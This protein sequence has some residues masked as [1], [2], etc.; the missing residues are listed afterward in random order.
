MIKYLAVFLLLA[1]APVSFEHKGEEEK[2]L[3]PEEKVENVQLYLFSAPWCGPCK[4]MHPEIGRQ[5]K[6]AG[7]SAKVDVTL[8]VETGW[9]SQ[10][11][12]TEQIA[13]EYQKQL[14]LPEFTFTPDPWKWLTFKKYMGPQ[15][16]I[17]G[18]AVLDPS[19]VLVKK[20]APGSFSAQHVVDYLKSILR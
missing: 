4:E 7:I 18:A 11:Q 14:G 16:A 9:T 10:Q 20:F 12:P 3:P 17:P 8:W 5:I 15:L 1:C 13:A 6:A 2:P 19:D